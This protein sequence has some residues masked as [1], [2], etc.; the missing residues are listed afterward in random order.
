MTPRAVDLRL[1]GV[2]LLLLVEIALNLIVFSAY[3]S[4]SAGE[5]LFFP[6]RTELD[7]FSQFVTFPFR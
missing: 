5:E 4:T 7:L 2:L 1:I 3:N 6:S